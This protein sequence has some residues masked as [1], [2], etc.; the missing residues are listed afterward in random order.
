MTLEEV[1]QLRTGDQVFWNDPSPWDDSGYL[2]IQTIDV[3][4]EIIKI[5]TKNGYTCQCFAHELE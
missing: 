5:T 2:S 4:G 1:K 3:I